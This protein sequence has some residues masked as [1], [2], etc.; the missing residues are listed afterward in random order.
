[1][2][3]ASNQGRTSYQNAGRTLRRGLE[4]AWNA[5][6]TDD[7]R[8][9]LAYTWLD[10]RYRDDCSSG[11]CAAN[12]APERVIASGNRIPGIPEHVAWASLGWEPASGWRAGIEARYVGKVYVNDGNTEASPGY[13][14]TALAGGYVWFAGPWELNAF[15][16][17]DNLFNRRYAGSVIVNDGNG[18]YY[19]PAP[20]RNWAAGLTASYSF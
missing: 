5:H 4:L 6:L 3:A 15:A 1:M 13:F 14:T 8:V 18:R 2:V 11:G 17:I 20:G 10:A 9:D 19:E 7:W 12:A 16:R